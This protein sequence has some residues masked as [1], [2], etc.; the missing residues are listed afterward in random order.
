[1]QKDCINPFN[2]RYAWYIGVDY[3]LQNQKLNE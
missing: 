1:M 3:I 2:T